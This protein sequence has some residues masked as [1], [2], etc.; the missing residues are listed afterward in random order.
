MTMSEL[1]ALDSQMR[2]RVGR[3]PH[4]QLCGTVTAELTP[5]RFNAEWDV[6]DECWQLHGA[7]A[8]ISP[9]LKI[10]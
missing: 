2:I 3:I 9:E 1:N 10:R 7:D 5:A 8:R 4:C 6:C